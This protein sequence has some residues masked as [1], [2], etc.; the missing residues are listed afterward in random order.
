MDART[1]I[2]EYYDALRTGEP[3]WPYFAKEHDGDDRFVKFGISERLVGIEQIRRG[4]RD[5]TATT[6][7]WEVQSHALRVRER[8]CH[9]WFSD[10]V[11]MAW[12]DTNEARR[13]EFRTR[14]SGTLETTTDGWG[15]VGMHVS[16]ADRL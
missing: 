8:D 7:D 9:A 3:L 12:T 16:T 14:W 2:T 15:F 13:L 5:Q 4:L 10:D 1:T 11:S 6:T